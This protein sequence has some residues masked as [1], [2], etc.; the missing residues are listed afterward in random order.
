MPCH[1]LRASGARSAFEPAPPARAPRSPEER[2]KARTPSRPRR[3]GSIAGDDAAGDFILHGEDIAELAVVLFGPV[4]A[5]VTA[6]ISC[7]LTRS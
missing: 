6:S 4:M 1:N 7:A 2:E 5:A 3:R